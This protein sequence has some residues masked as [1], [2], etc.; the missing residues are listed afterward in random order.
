VRG[1]GLLQMVGLV[2][3]AGAGLL[4]EFADLFVQKP[5][6]QRLVTHDRRFGQASVGAKPVVVV[7]RQLLD[8]GQRGGRRG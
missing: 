1:W 7:D 3:H 8:R 2:L 4:R 6:A 5:A